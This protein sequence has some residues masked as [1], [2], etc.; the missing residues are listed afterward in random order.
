[1][2]SISALRVAHELD[3]LLGEPKSIASNNCPILQRAHDSTVACGQAG[4]ERF[5]A[6]F[7]GPLRD[8]LLNGILFRSLPHTRPVLE[9]WRGPPPS[10][11]NR[12]TSNACLQFRFDKN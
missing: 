1:T 12:A 7:I 8:E 2:P 10:P 11:P 5:A 9:A 6:S 3:R 4:A